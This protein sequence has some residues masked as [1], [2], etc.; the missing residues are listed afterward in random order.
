MSFRILLASALLALAG[1]AQAQLVGGPREGVDYVL[2]EGAQPFTA[3]RGKIEVAEVFAYTCI[4]CARLDPII[5]EW[6]ARQPEHVNAVK[7]PVSFGGLQ[8]TL[9]RAHYAAE[10]LGLID[11]AGPALFEALHVRGR[12]L[13]N[14]NDIVDF[15]VEQ[16]ADRDQLTATMRSFSV[17]ARINRGRQVL[18]RWNIEGTPAIVVAGKYRVMAPAAGGF[19]AM[20][21]VVDQLVERERAAAN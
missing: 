19:E 8:E 13:R 7:I 5:N 17:N 11:T 10:A 12:Q 21:Q 6:K 18:P 3:D 14:E 15:F 9:A 1:T 16:G 4:H 2:L 20:L